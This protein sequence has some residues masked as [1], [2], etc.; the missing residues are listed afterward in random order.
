MHNIRIQC[1][2]N[3][4]DVNRIAANETALLD[5]SYYGNEFTAMAPKEGKMPLSILNGSHCAKLA[6]PHLQQV[7]LAIKTSVSI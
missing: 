7:N 1:Q 4:L 5:N 2:K 3:S 6:Y